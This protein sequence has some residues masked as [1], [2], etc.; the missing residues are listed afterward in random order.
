MAVILKLDQNKTYFLIKPF[1]SFISKN[2]N[3]INIS[4]TNY[5]PFFERLY[6]I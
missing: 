2:L 4:K 5:L 1:L 3:I 6:K